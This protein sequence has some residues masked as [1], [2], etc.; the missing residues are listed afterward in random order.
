[1]CQSVIRAPTSA[2]SSIIEREDFQ[3]TLGWVK[4]YFAYEKSAGPRTMEQCL[5][6]YRRI[7]DDCDQDPKSVDNMN[8]KAGG[9]L[10]IDKVTY[11]IAPQKYR[12]PWVEKSTAG[13]H[14]NGFIHDDHSEAAIEIFRR[15]WQ[16]V[17]L[18]ERFKTHFG[19]Q[20]HYGHDIQYGTDPLD[21]R[22]WTL[23]VNPRF[24]ATEV[25]RDRY[26]GW[27]HK[28]MNWDRIPREKVTCSL[29]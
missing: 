14:V 12:E 25:G 7:L 21:H 3:E 17:N 28:A 22:E 6:G 27:I 19:G 18:G 8:W 20:I 16:G 10:K 13:C 11:A 24:R 5:E 1:M 26:E 9:E 2:Q 15:G 23:R 29:T 4:F